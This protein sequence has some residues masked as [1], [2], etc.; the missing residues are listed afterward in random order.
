MVLKSL[1][2]FGVSLCN[3]VPGVRHNVLSKAIRSGR[4]IEVY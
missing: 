2:V 1:T 3:L 4:N